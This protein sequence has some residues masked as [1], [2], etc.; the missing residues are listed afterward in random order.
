MATRSE[1]HDGAV[2]R[3]RAAIAEQ[4]Q[5]TYRY[6]AAIGAS[7][8][9]SADAAWPRRRR[10]GDGARRVAQMGR[11]RRLPRAERGTLRAPARARRLR[12][13][14]RTGRCAGRIRVG[15]GMSAPPATTD[16]GRRERGRRPGADPRKHGRWD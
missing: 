1:A 13:S 9:T 2:R 6:E 12:V 5:L 4:D 16:D 11:R 10:T 3:L 7:A 15:P 14:A 8:E